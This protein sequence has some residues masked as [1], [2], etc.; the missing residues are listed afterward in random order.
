MRTMRTGPGATAVHIVHPSR[1]APGGAR[2]IE[3]REFAHYEQAS[4][5]LIAV[6]KQWLA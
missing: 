1:R 6:A 2:D 3:H 4:E 5:M